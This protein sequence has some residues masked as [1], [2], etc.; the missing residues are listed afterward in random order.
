MRFGR[1]SLALTLSLLAL[2]GPQPSNPPRFT[3]SSPSLGT[4]LLNQPLSRSALSATPRLSDPIGLRVIYPALTD[5]VRVRDSSFLFG[6]VAH[7]NVSVAVNGTPARV[8]PSGG[9][10]AW[11]P[12]PQD[13]LM[14]FR[15]EARM[16]G[17]SSILLYPVRR[18]PRYFPGIA[19]RGSVWVD[20]M[21]FSPAGQAWLPASEYLTFSA[22][23]VEGAV[24]RL[25]LPDGNIVRLLPQRQ[26]GDVLPGARAFER[27]TM[28]LRTADEVRYVGVVRGRRMGPDPGPVLRGPSAALVGVL[29]RAARRCVTGERCPAPYDELVTPEGPWAILEAAKDGDTLRLR[30]P[31]QVSILDTMP[32]V[33]EFDDDTA[34]LG[35]TDSTTPGRAVPGGTYH[36]FFPTG[37]RAAVTGRINEDLRLH[38]SPEAEAWAPVGDAQG[39]PS[40]MPTPQAIVSS[41][42]LTAAADRVTLRIPVSERVPFLVSEAESSLAVR[43]YSAAGDVDWMRYGRD[44]LVKRLSWSQPERGEVMLTV[45]LAAPVWGY[46]THWERNDLLLEIRRPPKISRT[47]PLRGRTI[48]VDPGHPPLGATGPTGLREADANLAV[49]LRLRK[50]LESAGARV[51]MTRTTDTAVDLWERVAVADTGGAELLI[52]IHNNAL[53]DGVNPFTNN[54]TSVFYNQPRSVPL[55]TAIQRGLVRRLKLPDLGISRGDLAV[56]RATWMPAALSEG[57][58]LIMPDQEA[59]LR[60]TQGQ[61]SY[62]RGVFDGIERFLRDR[63]QLQSPPGVGR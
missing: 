29:A 52:S 18:D 50:L 53:P 41:V 33:A 17:D 5:L 35:D 21:A 62:A 8:W 43:L 34:G 7:G 16:G 6:S 28:K 37:T 12:F 40:G 9:W 56:V 57:M 59:A 19:T 61:S 24:L 49:A 38:L 46:R 32:L 10:L 47:H 3:R 27:D 48:A 31:V 11:V 42:T 45:E 14:R 2:R 36:W 23:A 55:A 13:T 22:R 20:S 58:F 25:H 26:P 30:W 44:S 54:G 1:F 39:L 63:A 4:A 60:S 15:I 51:L